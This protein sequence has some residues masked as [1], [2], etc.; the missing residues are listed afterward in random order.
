MDLYFDDTM[1]QA[2]RRYAGSVTSA[3]G[4]SGDCWCVHG[5]HPVGLYLAL[6][7]RLA[8]F[9]DHDVALLWDERRGWSV[10][11]EVGED[12]V[13]LERLDGLAVPRP[14]AVAEWVAGLFLRSAAGPPLVGDLRPSA[15]GDGRSVPRVPVDQVPLPRSPA[16]R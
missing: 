5:E 12:L 15:S 3:L 7:G 9:P 16:A 13:V 10:A 1:T 2:L 11:V 6:D 14:V 8:S 4:L